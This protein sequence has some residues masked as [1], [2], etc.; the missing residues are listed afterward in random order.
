MTKKLLFLVAVSGLIFANNGCTS[1]KADDG[2]QVVEN[3][4][5]EKIDADGM[6]TP[7][8][9]ASLES[10]LGETPTPSDTSAAAAP[11]IDDSSLS[12]DT[13]ET[14]P[15]T[16][17]AP[18]IPTPVL[19]EAAPPTI[20][21]TPLPP[22][23]TT[24]VDTAAL[25]AS[26]GS[27]GSALMETA[28]PPADT[29]GYSSDV[30]TS[31]PAASS[32]KKVS[33]TM[34]YQGKDGA[35]INTVYIARPKEKLVDISMKIFGTD[36][37]KEL[38]K[39]AE[40]K[41]LKSRAAKA[42]DKI[43]YTSPNRPDDAT[44]TMLYYEDMGM[45]PE[46]Y[47]AKKG[48]SLKKVSKELL[49]YDNAWREVWASNGVESKTSLKDGE[50]LRYWKSADAAMAAAPGSGTATLVDST[51]AP[52]PTAQIEPPAALPP[53]PTDANANLPPP[54]DPNA[55]A[56]AGTDA[57]AG[58]PPPPPADLAPPPPPP[59]PDASA[60]AGEA[61]EPKKKINLDEVAAAEEGVT[62]ELDSDTMMSMGALGVLVAMMAFVIIRKKKQKAQMMGEM[63]A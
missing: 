19:E 34:P 29:G 13:A 4:D 56:A 8:S 33:A 37:T 30:A 61:G 23:D 42:G 52:P 54:P 38:K 28:A 53:P 43:Y 31:K 44:K 16:A 45:V 50:T 21:E 46:I 9:D 41:Y 35:W 63:N 20:T 57:N 51:Q 1:K 62:G 12:L 6:G 24:T 27:S 11:T 5:I 14:P 10:A 49:G 48:E 22:T 47:V 55:A 3:A 25:A 58:L 60:L 15:S 32:I 7:A 17:N 18:D 40:N 26:L 2:E 59:P 36:K 39:I